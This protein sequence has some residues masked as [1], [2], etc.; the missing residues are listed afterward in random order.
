M[1]IMGRDRMND[2]IQH[3]ISQYGYFLVFFA[4]MIE[5]ESVVIAA[6]ILASQGR[7]D[8]VKVVTLVFLGTLFADQGMFF[9]GRFWG[10]KLLH[11]YPALAAKSARVFD[12]L[13]RYNTAFIMIF[14]FVYGIRIL[15]PII[16][17]MSGVSIKRFMVLNLFAAI[18]WTGLSCGAGYFLG[19]VV[20]SALHKSQNILYYGLGV[21]I[22]VFV[23]WFLRKV[24]EWYF[25]EIDEYE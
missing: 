16:I 6:S 3:F 18:L 23:I 1:T 13:K 25:R 4:S 14:R 21:I 19:D 15:S 2:T 17:G 8:I 5:G 20:L 24:S 7:M 11:R 22:I 9:V 10:S 12:F